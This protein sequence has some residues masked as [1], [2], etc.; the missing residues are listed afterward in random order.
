LNLFSDGLKKTVLGTTDKAN[1]SSGINVETLFPDFAKWNAGLSQDNWKATDVISA[2]EDYGTVNRKGRNL[3][4]I[5]VKA[6]VKMASAERGQYK[7]ECFLFGAV[8]DNEFQMVR[9]PY[10]TKC[11]ET[12]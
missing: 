5:V 4:G 8:V 3:D 12:Q 11:N 10:E 7:D 1:T 2:V 6:T 9:D